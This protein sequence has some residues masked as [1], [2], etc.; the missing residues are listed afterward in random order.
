MVQ[1]LKEDVLHV[2]RPIQPLPQPR[3]VVQV[4]HLDTGL[5]VLVGVK[6]G[7]A[8]LGGAK[9]LAPQPLL[10]IGILEDV[11]GHEDLG[12]LRNDQIGF[13]HPLAGN[14][15]ELFYQL[16]DIQGYTIADDVGDMGV[17]RARG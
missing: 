16:D 14:A 5:G 12:P 9:G 13:G 6:W 4:A 8:A 17:K 1:V 2:H 3:L 10:L 11:V 7:D 15:P